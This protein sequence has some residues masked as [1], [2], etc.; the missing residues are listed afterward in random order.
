MI[1]ND[2]LKHSYAVA[3]KMIEIGKEYK[4]SNFEIQELFVLGLNNVIN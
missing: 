3:K 1:D 4:L 2:R